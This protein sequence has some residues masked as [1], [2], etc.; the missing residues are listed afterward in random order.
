MSNPNP[1]FSVARIHNQTNALRKREGREILTLGHCCVFVV[2]RRRK[3]KMRER[4][5][6]FSFVGNFFGLCLPK[7]GTGQ[8]TWLFFWFFHFSVTD[9]P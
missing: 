8:A 3:G 6:K 9:P 2:V 7:K 5:Q 4:E 1:K